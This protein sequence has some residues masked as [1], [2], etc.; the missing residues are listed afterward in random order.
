MDPDPTDRVATAPPVSD[1]ADA[2]SSASRVVITAEQACAS[3]LPEVDIAM[4]EGREDIVALPEEG[5]YLRY[6]APLGMGRSFRLRAARPDERG[7]DGLARA[8]KAAVGERPVTFATHWICG[9]SREYAWVSTESYVPHHG[10]VTTWFQVVRIDVGAAT[11]YAE[12]SSTNGIELFRE[13][14]V[15]EPGRIPSPIG[16][17]IGRRFQLT[18]RVTPANPDDATTGVFRARLV[19][20]DP[21][22][23]SRRVLPRYLVT[24]KPRGAAPHPAYAQVQS[25]DEA[26]GML[27]LA[28]FGNDGDHEVLV[29]QVPADAEFPVQ[30]TLRPAEAAHTFHG[31]HR[32]VAHAHQ[33][34]EAFGYLRPELAFGSPV[35]CVTTRPELF[36]GPSVELFHESFCAPEVVAGERPTPSADVYSLCAI[37][38]HWLTGRVAPKRLAG[39]W[40]TSG[41]SGVL[42]NGLS[43][44]PQERLGLAALA[45]E[46]ERFGAVEP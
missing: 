24:L 11:L 39:L 21:R 31:L 16:R 40:P 30:R 28:V 45:R 26:I 6:D 8:M 10:Q 3:G 7:A 32:I 13:L 4:E 38:A 23:V 2:W 12:L 41:F 43:E 37:L 35:A 9:A 19:G 27:R 33:L 14:R 44:S 18:G 15:L 29:E 17:V 25:W 36:A 46:V 34:G 5:M 22:G 1:D 20:E 42:L